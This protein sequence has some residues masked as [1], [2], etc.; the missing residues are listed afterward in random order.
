MVLYF[1]V[2]VL[3]HAF[4][5]FWLIEGVGT[6]WALISIFFFLM[7]TSWYATMLN[8]A[9]N[10]SSTFSYKKVISADRVGQRI[11][12][13]YAIVFVI[14][15]V[16][17]VVE[18]GALSAFMYFQGTLHISAI[19]LV[20]MI[21]RLS[22]FK[23]IQ[24][25]WQPIRIEL[26][27]RFKF[28]TGFRF[29]VKGD[30][31]AESR[32]NQYYEEYITINPLPGSVYLDKPRLAFIQK[33]LFVKYDETLHLAK[34]YK[35]ETMLEF[36]LLLLVPKLKGQSMYS[37]N[38]IIYLR[39]YKDLEGMDITSLTSNDFD[40]IEAVYIMPATVNIPVPPTENSVGMQY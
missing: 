5:D 2:A 21:T 7:G 15:L 6:V 17:N 29:S 20:S 36:D 28:G 1:I 10:N 30:S 34:V 12:I 27:F 38:P 16:V 14:Q 24:G 11:F 35:D 22:R 25:R 26:P 3:S 40:F 33:K 19:I 18:M 23:L 9:L 8:N 37:G 39:R 4:Y 31:I 32:L 13:Y